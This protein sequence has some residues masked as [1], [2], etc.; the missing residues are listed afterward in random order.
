MYMSVTLRPLMNTAFSAT[1][2]PAKDRPPNVELPP[3]TPGASSATALRSCA[4]GRRCSSAVDVERGFGGGHIHAVDHARAD[5]LQRVE[6]DHA[7]A[8][9]Q[10]TVVVPPIAT[11]TATG[12]PSFWPSRLS[13][14]W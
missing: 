3:T 11:L 2:E 14:S 4:T 8:T 13:C 5:H 9:G 7:A 1:D 6:V 10:F 12:S